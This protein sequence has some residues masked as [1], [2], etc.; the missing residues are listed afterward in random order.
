MDTFLGWFFGVP[1]LLTIAWWII[2]PF[3]VV[4]AKA[5]DVLATKVNNDDD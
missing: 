2:M 1:I 3:I 4:G 5:F